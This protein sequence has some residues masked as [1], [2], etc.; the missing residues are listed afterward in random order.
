MKHTYSLLY[1]RKL[2]N[3]LPSLSF[4]VHVMLALS[5]ITYIMVA[6]L[7]VIEL[8]SSARSIQ[9]PPEEIVTSPSNK[10]TVQLV[11]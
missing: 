5:F 10:L 2:E 1:R 3:T 4:I 11:S 6:Q 8:S 7:M 9:Q